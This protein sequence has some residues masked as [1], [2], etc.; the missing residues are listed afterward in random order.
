MMKEIVKLLH[1][2]ALKTWQHRLEHGKRFLILKRNSYL[3]IWKPLYHYSKLMIFHNIKLRNKK[4]LAFS[5]K[6]K[7]SWKLIWAISLNL[8]NFMKN[9]YLIKNIYKK[10]SH[11]I[12]WR[13]R[14]KLQNINNAKATNAWKWKN[15]FRTS[16]LRKK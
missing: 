9:S 2:L 1:N 8:C 5:K 15:S 14:S 16:F 7:N 3:F 13:K 6:I 11:K 12:I 10:I 4:L